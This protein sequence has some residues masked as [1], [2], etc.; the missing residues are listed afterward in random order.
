VNSVPI[1]SE[2]WSEKTIKA[3]PGLATSE[4]SLTRI[5]FLYEREMDK[6]IGAVDRGEAQMA[7]LLKPVRVERVTEI[8]F[9]G[10][11]L[12][13]KSTDFYPSS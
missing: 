13:Q 12:P 11:V 2:I 8:A 7:C 6:A 10:G 5:V 1:R 4:L 9:E 3:P